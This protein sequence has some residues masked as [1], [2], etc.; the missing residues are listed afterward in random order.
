MRRFVW[1]AV[2]LTWLAAVSTGVASPSYAFARPEGT[3]AGHIALFEGHWIDLSTGWG[4]ARACDILPGRPTRCFR[5]G[6]EAH[7]EEALIRQPAVSCSTPLR[8][9]G[10]TYQTGVTIS[11]YARGVWVDL[12][13]YGFDNTTSSYT[14]GACSI[15]LASLAGGGG[16]RYTRCLPAGCVENVMDNGWN[17][18]VSSVYLH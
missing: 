1:V 7:A 10:G 14:V 13:D 2:L 15:E 12:A 5:T 4:H 18:V 3:P 16:F 8:L 6:V 11:I 9:H 17:N